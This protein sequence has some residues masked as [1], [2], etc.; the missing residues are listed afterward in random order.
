MNSSSPSFYVLTICWNE[1][2]F[3]PYFLRHYA[4]ATKIVIFD[5]M[6]SDNSVAIMK[7]YPNVEICPYHT[8]AQIRDD[9]YLEIKNHAWKQFAHLCDWVIVVDIDELIYHPLGIPAFVQTLAPH[10]AVVKCA[11]YE[12]FSP[13]L[14][15]NVG[16]LPTNG[17]PA[18]KLDKQALFNTKLVK[19]MNYL[20][21]CHEAF[22]R[23]TSRLG[24]TYTHSDFKML[25]YKF[26]HPLPKMI[27]RYK[28][29]AQRLSPQNRQNGW[30]FHYN[31]MQSLILKY[32]MLQK[33][34]Q[35]I[36]QL[37]PNALSLFF[38]FICFY[39]LFFSAFFGFWRTRIK[40]NCR[41]NNSR[42]LQTFIFGSFV[43]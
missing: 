3:L 22:P 26:I 16:A 5:N 19:E 39:L 38:A 15:L 14:S 12:M 28:L 43:L 2:F 25:H 9:I 36:I 24:T 32:N 7:Q 8:N 20:T 34:H 40:F 4:F 30:G 41:I 13:D 27:Q 37:W 10:V 18:V 33:C 6:S 35:N 23:M 21:G 31:N 1:E 17:Y 29:M 42:L 11:G